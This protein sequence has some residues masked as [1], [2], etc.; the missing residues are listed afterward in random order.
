MPNNRVRV[1][2]TG[3]GAIS[4][5]GNSAEKTWQGLVAGRSG[6]KKGK[7]FDAS[8]YP[9]KI[10]AEVTDFEPKQFMSF[11][12]ARRMARFSQLAVAAAREAL[13]GASLIK[14]ESSGETIISDADSSRMGVIIGTSVGGFVE[15]R[16]ATQ[17]LLEKGYRRVGPMFIPKMMH[18]AASANISHQ[19]GIRGYNSTTTTACAAGTQAIGEA[20]EVIRRGKADI[21]LTGGTE[22]PISDVGQ[23]GFWATRAMTTSHSETPEQ[24]SRPFDLHRD[25]LVIGEGAACLVLERL[26]HALAR[27]VPILAEVL[28]FGCSG[29]AYHLTA[30]DPQGG[31]EVRAMTWAL[32]DAGIPCSD[33]DYVNA[34]ATSTPLGD[35][36]ETLAIKHVF[37]ELAYELPIS[38]AKSMLGHAIA[39]SGAIEAIASI[40]TIRD[41]IIHPTINYDTPDPECDLDYVPNKSRKSQ[42]DV[43]LSNSF[44]MGGQN[45]AL[46]F[47]RV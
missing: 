41:N 25:G 12:E 10:A 1:V 39:A 28:G 6:V 47:G 15:V 42:V 19:F 16:N 4:A 31:G 23:A 35:T 45:A 37:G 11:K 21:M 7:T 30:P 22:A 46:L 13:V 43:V 20:T 17:T 3:I 26:E 8:D 44:G 27:S 34:H 29:D 9:I 38:A 24:A 33:V 32:E 14:E 5:L 18:N 2:V 36:I 40:F